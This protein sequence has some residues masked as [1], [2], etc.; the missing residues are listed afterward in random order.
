MLIKFAVCCQVLSIALN[1]LFFV[2]TNCYAGFVLEKRIT[3][4][5]YAF[6]SP[7]SIHNDIIAIGDPGKINNVN[8][9]D[10]SGAVYLYQRNRG[11]V[12]GWGI[13]KEFLPPKLN[14]AHFGR[15][16][17]L[18]GSTLVVGEGGAGE[19]VPYKTSSICIFDRNHGGIDNWGLVQQLYPPSAEYVGTVSVSGD[20][21]AASIY[22]AW[23]SYPY[24]AGTVV[25]YQRNSNSGVWELIQ[26]I[27]P[28]DLDYAQHFGDV[29][30]VSLSGSSLVVGSHRNNDNNI[31]D[32]RPGVAYLFEQNSGG[33]NNWGPVKTL[34]AL[35]AN[36]A[37]WNWFGGAVALMGDTVV[38]GAPWDD[39]VGNL[40]GSAYIFSRNYPSTGKWGLVKKITAVDSVAKDNFGEQVAIYENSV[41]IGTPSKADREAG[42]GA[43]YVYERDNGG[44]SKWGQT[45]K[46]LPAGIVG[47]SAFGIGVSLYQNLLVTGSIGSA[48]VFNKAAICTS[49]ISPISASFSNAGGSSLVT[50]TPSGSNCSWGTSESLSWVS[51]SPTSGQG[52]GRVTVTVSANKGTARNGTVIIAGKTYTIEQKAQSV[53]TPILE[54]LLE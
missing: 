48:Y 51:L 9:Y 31:M 38:I 45:Q 41:I 33:T 6:G 8:S 12:Q 15:S 42:T 19:D 27:E 53:I 18:N 29:G 26:K 22:E 5:T 11:G 7:V 32:N 43:V 10:D 52:S 37:D 4:P 14:H 35:D 13:I 50:V 40:S 23:N 30:G 1:F 34:H 54:L 25:I 39:A 24:S 47:G 16:V 3:L 20:I 28:P 17:S 49:S 21:L 44:S 36:P 2:H 46:I